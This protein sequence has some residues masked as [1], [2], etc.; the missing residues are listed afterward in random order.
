GHPVLALTLARRYSTTATLFVSRLINPPSLVD[1][2]LS[3]EVKSLLYQDLLKNSDYQ[4]F[5][6]RLA[7]LIY[8]ANSR[9][10]NTICRNISPIIGTSP[11]VMMDCLGQAIIEGD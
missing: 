11:K 9:V 3:Q 4:N 2:D 5:V 10:I 8:P 7:V 6:Q 1:E